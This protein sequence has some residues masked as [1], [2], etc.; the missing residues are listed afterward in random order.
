[1]AKNF[2]SF[3]HIDQNKERMKIL[4]YYRALFLSDPK[5]IPSGI[6]FD[7]LYDYNHLIDSCI[8]QLNNPPNENYS[9]PL[10]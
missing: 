4:N 2:E 7:P 8:Q 9:K 6:V 1:L 5:F 3:K 10:S